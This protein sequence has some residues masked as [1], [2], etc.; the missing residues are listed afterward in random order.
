MFNYLS[1]CIPTLIIRDDLGFFFSRLF[2]SHRFDVF[3]I[4]RIPKDPIGHHPAICQKHIR[5]K[6]HRDHFVIHLDNNA[7]DPAANPVKIVE[8]MIQLGIPRE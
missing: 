5:A 4:Q 8:G 3:R 6:L 7:V 2:A 1:T